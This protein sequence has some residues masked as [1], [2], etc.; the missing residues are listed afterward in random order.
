MSY[1]KSVCWAVGCA[2]MLLAAVPAWSAVTLVNAG[3]PAAK[4]VVDPKGAAG[5]GGEILNDSAKWLVD[6]LQ[7][8]SGAALPLA[9][10]ADE[11]PVV[12][13]GVAEAYPQQAA[14]VQNNVEAY[15]ITTEG[16]RV[17]L[18][19]KT[20]QGTRHAVAHVLRELGF[21]YYA[22]SPKW[23]IVPKHETITIDLNVADAPTLAARSIWYAYGHGSQK[24]LME[25]YHQWVRGNR[26]SRGSGP[27]TGHSYG[28]IVDRNKAEFDAHPEY[29]A[30]GPDGKRTNDKVPAAR[31]FCYSN[32]GLIKLV[33][34][35]RVKLMEEQR[36]RN[37]DAYM[38][39]VDPSDGQGTCHCENCKALGN[40]SDRVF[41]LANEV[42]KAIRAK[43]PDGW[44]GLYA[45]SSHRLPPTIKIEP[46]VYVQVAMGFNRTQYTLPELVGLWSEKVSAVGL[47][48]YYG[49][50]AWDW[51]LPGRMRG[52]SVSYHAKWI[53]YY[54][55][56]K[57]NAVNAE[58]NANWGAQMLG[59][60]VAAQLMWN[61]RAD[62][63][64][65]VE[66]FF[67]L[68]YA[69]AA[70]P[71][72]K[73]QEGFDKAP[74]LRPTVL[75]PLFAE[76][77]KAYE[78]AQSPEVRARIVDMMAY[79]EYVALY[80][81]FDLAS[82]RDGA[83]RGDGHYGALKPLMQYAWQIRDRDIVHYYALARRLCNG[84]PKTDNRLDFWIGNKESN[85][86]WMTGEQL[87]D[88]EIV[89]RFNDR[90]KKLSSE[91]DPTV[92]YTRY[93]E[94]VRVPGVDAGSS[95]TIANKEE[96]G[97]I[98]YRKKLLGYVA[99]G[100]PGKIELL[101]QPA[102]KPVKV[103][104]YEPGGKL[105]AEHEVSDKDKLTPV[106]FEFSRAN[107]YRIEFHGDAKIKVPE[108]VAIMFEASPTNPAW[109]ESCGPLYFY[110][111][112]S[113]NQVFV[114]GRPR[115]SIVAPGQN[116]L[117][118]VAESVL[119]GKQ[120]AAVD[121]PDGGAG[122]VWYISSMTRGQAALLN[123]PPLFSVHRNTILVPREVAEGDQLVTAGEDKQ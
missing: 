51:G 20:A 79:M 43:F 28:S 25:T 41:H 90:I 93:F 82:N 103:A 86:V 46:N 122:Q 84:V 12:I 71:M 52:A 8:S 96:T 45:Y 33:C 40:E 92:V 111:P 32:P 50:E 23:H 44:V 18:I 95:T 98:A 100:G 68:T 29:S 10:A 22:P 105:I 24:H 7:Q 64:P 76:V 61:P 21:R 35:D 69:E 56:R 99:L 94:P 31:K 85:P 65:M 2:A 102:A 39:S 58:T 1:R 36:K 13:L 67:R 107:D 57:L 34:E 89:Q 42:A 83:T 120:Y 115:L 48:E 78:L 37:P 54:A 5:N 9:A 77:A 63:A 97:V 66:E 6:A 75:A 114:E 108:S 30:M 119:P 47:R 113:T 15:A 53:P 38:V 59:L 91:D 121:V 123:V 72:R 55:E 80:R 14:K 81:E 4:V 26:L 17:Y 87:T 11:G 106:S 118:I 116:R 16:N 60:Y 27:Q 62:V 101:V 74:A 3:Q 49:V 19:G 109:I 88:E 70:E 73:L 112:K 117:D 104:A 110:V